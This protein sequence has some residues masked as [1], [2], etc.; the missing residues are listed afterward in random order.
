MLG[1][2]MMPA[3]ILPEG[4]SRLALLFPASHAMRAFAGGSG[5]AL[6]FALLAA[7]AI[8]AFA[9]ALALYEWDQK[10]ARAPLRKLLAV[11]AFAPYLVAAAIG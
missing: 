1:G 9:A 2:L 3:S 5:A 4:L 7:G 8:L 11:A 6:S 10:N